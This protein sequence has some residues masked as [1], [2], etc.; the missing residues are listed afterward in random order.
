MALPFIGPA[1]LNPQQGGGGGITTVKMNPA[2]VRFPTARRQAQR[3]SV[4][5]TT[6]EKFAPLAP[7]SM[8]GIFSAFQKQPDKLTDEQYLQ[9]IGAEIIENPTTLEDVKSN[10][11][12]QT[13]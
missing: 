5:P 4:E 2:Q 8:E 9:S 7:L 12:A 1:S 10:T 13:Q 11:R 6:K 3:R